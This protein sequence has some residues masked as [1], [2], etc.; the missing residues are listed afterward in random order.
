MKQL[1]PSDS[2]QPASEVGVLAV[3]LDRRVEAADL[4]QRVSSDRKVATVENRRR[5]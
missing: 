3:K 2:K 1:D 4:L 5:R